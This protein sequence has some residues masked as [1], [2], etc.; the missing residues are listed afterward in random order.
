MWVVLLVGLL[1]F[2]VF[3]LC[4]FNDDGSDLVN[5]FF[6]QM[7]FLDQMWVYGQDGGLLMIFGLI[8]D[9]IGIILNLLCYLLF[10]EQVEV[11]FII[12]KVVYI[13]DYVDWMV[14]VF[15]V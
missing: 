9:F 11:I 15:V 1:C 6:D 14:L 12:D 7:V 3:E 5:I 4:Y 8:V 13:V 2:L 10:V